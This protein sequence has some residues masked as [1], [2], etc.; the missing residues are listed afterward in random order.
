MSENWFQELKRQVD[1]FLDTASNE[2]LLE[3]LRE[4]D[5][6]YYKNMFQFDFEEEMFEFGINIVSPDLVVK[7]KEYISSVKYDSLDVLMAD[8]YS[9]NMAA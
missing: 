7:R 3:M 1:A 5:Y 2:E 4:A 8:D 9:Y 6:E